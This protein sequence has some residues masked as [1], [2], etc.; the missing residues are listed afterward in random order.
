MEGNK[1][2]DPDGDSS[3]FLLAVAILVLI[4]VTVNKLYS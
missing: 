1:L 4:L 2:Q 3:G